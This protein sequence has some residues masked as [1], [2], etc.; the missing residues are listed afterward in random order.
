MPSSNHLLHRVIRETGWTYEALA[1]RLN[2]S[3]QAAGLTTGY[4]RTSVAH[5]LRGS[6][7]RDPVPGLLCEILAGRLNRPVGPADIGMDRAG[8]DPAPGRLPRA[9]DLLA[10]VPG[11]HPHRRPR[12]GAGEPGAGQP[13][14]GQPGVGEP[15]RVPEQRE[16]GE[17]GEGGKHERGAAAADAEGGQVPALSHT[18]LRRAAESFFTGQI[19]ALGGD[20]TAPVLLAYLQ[21]TFRTALTT[22]GDGSLSALEIGHAARTVLLLARSYADQCS[23]DASRRTLSRAAS[24]AELAGEPSTQA[25]ALRMLSQDALDQNQSAVAL[26]YVTRALE[27]AP[28]APAAVRAFV[29]AQAAHVHA[30]LGHREQALVWLETADR[31]QG[32]AVGD[33]DP[34]HTYRPAALYFKRAVVLGLLGDHRAAHE[35][36]D[37]SLAARPAQQERAIMLTHVERARLYRLG[38]HE[39]EAAAE[40][41][42]AEALN[43]GVHSP[44]A[45]REIEL[46]GQG[47]PPR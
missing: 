40:L 12:G 20:A 37:A 16:R 9:A 34:F 8:H 6:T 46:L 42:R 15:H 22:R 3:A 31:L 27:V 10:T 30:A 11:L 7:P 2:A 39:R 13:G 43:R 38:G 19:D 47:T 32:G 44:R 24:L 4:D 1:R 41:R 36:L 18:E 5:W 26:S 25:I 21:S 45:T 23:F 14:A 35:A 33:T 28:C 29:A 17:R